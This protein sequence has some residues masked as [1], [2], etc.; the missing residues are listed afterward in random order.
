MSN[1]LE[2]TIR[3]RRLAASKGLRPMAFCKVV[4]AGDLPM[5]SPG[6]KRV[7]GGRQAPRVPRQISR[8]PS[9]TSGRIAIE[10]A[11]LR[12]GL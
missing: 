7:S 6:K 11:T 9:R 10:R 2:L 1:F 3:G 12:R 5:L 8:I 4:E